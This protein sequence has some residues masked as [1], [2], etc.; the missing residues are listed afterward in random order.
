MHIDTIV[1]IFIE[2]TVPINTRSV[3]RKPL[4]HNW[5]YK[6]SQCFSS[7]SQSAEKGLGSQNK[8]EIFM[9]VKGVN[10]DQTKKMNN[11]EKT[12]GFL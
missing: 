12:V 11:D 7:Q 5:K 9:E 8:P 10:F 3:T 1:K 2:F 4:F 6:K